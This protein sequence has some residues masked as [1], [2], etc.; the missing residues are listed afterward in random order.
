MI[1][2]G[3]VATE[4]LRALALNPLTEVA[5]VCD[6]DE[7]LVR[8]RA[9]EFG[10]TGYTDHVE[11]LE[12]GD[13]DWVHVGTPVQTH[14]DLAMDAIE[15]GVDVLVEKPITETYEQYEE[16]QAA[17]D[18]AGVR[19]TE[20]HTALYHPEVRWLRERVEAGAVGEVRSVEAYFGEDLRPDSLFRGDWVLDLPGG[21]L[22]EGFAHPVYCAL[23]LGG[24]PTDA[25]D[26]SVSRV[27]KGDYERDFAYDGVAVSYPTERDAL[28]T[29]HVQSNV[30]NQ[31]TLRVH[32]EDGTLEADLTYHALLPHPDAGDRDYLDRSLSAVRRNVRRTL[33]A[34]RSVA[35]TAWLYANEV[36][37]YNLAERLDRPVG[38]YNR[39]MYHLID[40]EARSLAEGEPSPIPS[41]EIRWTS[42]VIDRIR[43]DAEAPGT[44]D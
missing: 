12:E 38:T 18:E 37:Y 39:Q 25:E 30:P 22:E 36:S 43:G 35:H 13:L 42:R 28:T 7:D 2:L 40:A 4:H 33:T 3:V 23:R 20:V 21:E 14:Y 31:K 6:I 26:V 5:G 1:G 27:L 9:A 8:E 34:A 16:L 24:Y 19:L 15:R 11:M 29:V 44:G 17:A 41:D 10:G 32:G